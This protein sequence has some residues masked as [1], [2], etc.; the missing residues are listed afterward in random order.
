MKVNEHIKPI[1]I[2]R[3]RGE[4]VFQASPSLHERAHQCRP[5]TRK[6]RAGIGG[7]IR[8]MFAH[9]QT[10]HRSWARQEVRV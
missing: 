10:G 2:P 9:A 1:T 7:E 6:T 4:V 5:D 8:R 3:M